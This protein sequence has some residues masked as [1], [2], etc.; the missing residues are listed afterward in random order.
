MG[1][2]GVGKGCHAGI[3]QLARRR[4]LLVLLWGTGPLLETGR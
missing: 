1:G 4:S 3:V 2:T